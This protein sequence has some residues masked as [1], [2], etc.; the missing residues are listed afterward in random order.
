MATTRVFRSGEWVT[1]I[2]RTGIDDGP[3]YVLVH[4]I[5]MAHEYWSDVAEA[6][7]RTGTVYALDLPGFGE[8]PEPEHPPSMPAA[9]DLLAELVRA[10]RI[11]RPVL[12][13]HSA[14]AQ[15]VAEAAARHPELFPCIV[16]IGPTVNPRERTVAKQ[17]GR[18]AQDLVLA[19]PKVLTL[20]LVSYAK[21]GAGWYLESL[22]PVM[23]HEIER[24][25]PKIT[26]DTLVIRG[27]RDRIV[28]R[29]WAKQAAALV[30]NGRYAEVPGRGHETMITAGPLVAD[31][32]ARHAR[33]EA[34][35]REVPRT[36]P[37][38]RSG[39]PVQPDAPIASS[40]TVPDA[41]APLPPLAAAGWW[42]LDYL[43][44]V[45][46]QLRVLTLPNASKRWSTGDAGK[47]TILLLPGV[48]EHWS[49]MA[50]LGDDL[51]RHGYR[52]Q[53]VHGLGA[54]LLG[55]FETA[56]R[57]A[58]A[59]ERAP[60]PPAGFVMVAHSKGG[61]VGKRMLL[62]DADRRLGLIGVVA[63]ATPFGGSRL[64]RYLLDPG[65]REFLPE[66]ATITELTGAASMNSQI[67]SVFGTF[68]PH[69]PEGSVLAGAKNVQ[70]PV[71][72][73]FRILSAPETSAAVVAGIESFAVPARAA[74]ISAKT[75][76][77]A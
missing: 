40:A 49:F 68:D 7:G 63:I 32:I 26:A 28:P 72:G 45:R 6:L 19:H 18:L 58:R 10:E 8:A 44:A 67:V 60:T 34:V 13:G 16:L 56:A 20:G 70:V 54:N 5:G 42:A 73:H 27:E 11:E 15:V 23:E 30:P 3:D 17:A 43:D 75:P 76:R 37:T 41:P 12:V 22:A 35:G 61:L 33:G 74:T 9:G 1:L 50:P 47:P 25:L 4:G 14:G 31:L 66:G 38:V 24:T 52:V 2:T 51:N 55:I 64:A 29:D 39:E 48:Y 53:V 71:A 21:A 77:S 57:M 36:A 62:S 59:L 46:Q 65:L 69:V